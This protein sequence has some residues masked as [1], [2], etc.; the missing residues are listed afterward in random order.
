MGNQ[1]GDKNA[2]N[3]VSDF[4]IINTVN[5][6]MVVP[7]LNTKIHISMPFPLYFI[8]LLI[9]INMGDTT[10]LEPFFL[11]ILCPLNQSD[12]NNANE[13][14][15]PFILLAVLRKFLI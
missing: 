8:N 1:T 5:E 10:T 12:L 11:A 2:V 13:I 9:T 15:E 4:C 7:L 14:M 6:Y 3:T